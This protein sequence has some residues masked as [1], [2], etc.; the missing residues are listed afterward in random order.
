LVLLSIVVS[1]DAV[2]PGRCFYVEEYKMVTQ[3]SIPKSAKFISKK[4]SV[5][6]FHGD[7][8]SSAQ[9]KLSK[10]DYDKLLDE[11]RNDPQITVTDRIQIYF[12]EFERVL[13]DKK[14]ENIIYHFIRKVPKN[15]DYL[16]YIGFYNDG[17]TIFVNVCIV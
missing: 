15:S 9:I 6:D 12:E 16:L 13:H 7:Y 5:P 2:F 11:F 3:R 10:E 1:I 14:P 8:C 4:A 17:Q